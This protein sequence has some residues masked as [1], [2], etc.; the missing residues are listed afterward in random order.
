MPRLLADCGNTT[1]KLAEADGAFAGPFSRLP[2]DPAQLAAWFAAHPA[3]ELAIA[4]GAAAT[5]RVLLAAA[6]AHLR[7]RLVG[8]DLPL[9][10]LGQYPGCGIDR[11]LAGLAAGRRQREP[12]IVLDCGTATTISAWL[13]VAPLIDVRPVAAISFA[14]GLILPSARACLVGLHACA[15]ALPLVDPG[16]PEARADQHDTRAALSAGI[17]IGYGPMVASCLLKLR[18]ETGAQRLVV[19]GGDAGLILSSRIA[20][21][22]D[23]VPELVLQGLAWLA[24]TDQRPL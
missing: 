11:V 10:D 8:S 1:I 9:P 6:P 22:T 3:D 13:V 2:P 7:R 23:L 19:T 18:R 5:T 16:G 24:A 12:V 4:P 17:G 20:A 15:P 14:G 21:E